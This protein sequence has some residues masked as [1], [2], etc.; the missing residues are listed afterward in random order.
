MTRFVGIDPSTN[1]GVVELDALGNVI[2]EE[3]I[4]LETGMHST[5]AEIRKYGKEIV[6]Y[7]EQDSLVCVEGFSFNSKGQAVSTQY[8]I[9]YAIRFALIE[10]GMVWIEPT[11]SQVKKYA[12]GKG[13]AHKSEMILPLYKRWGYEHK[14]DNVRDAFILAQIA[15]AVRMDTADTKQQKEVVKAILEPQ[16]TKEKSKKSKKAV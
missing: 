8:G 13:N 4:T 5:V 2:R 7:L 12:T 3:E 1:T 15:R 16:E 14:S 6:N 10:R 9:G 11:P